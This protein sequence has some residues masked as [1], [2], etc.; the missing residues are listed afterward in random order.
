M[1][2]ASLYQNNI[3][4]STPVVLNR[5]SIYT[6]GVWSY[7]NPKPESA[8]LVFQNKYFYKMPV[9]FGLVDIGAIS[10]KQVLQKGKIGDYLVRGSTGEYTI[11]TKK[12][13]KELFPV[14]NKNSPKMANTSKNLKDP[15]FITKIVKGSSPSNSN[16]TTPPTTSTFKGY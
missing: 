9:P 14:P 7:Y 11:I 6:G 4:P 16:K 1:S 13:Y 10:P 8:D 12:Q 15:N 5:A 2:F 3:F